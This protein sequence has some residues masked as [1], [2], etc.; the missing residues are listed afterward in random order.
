MYYYLYREPVEKQEIKQLLIRALV[1][2]NDDH[3]Q[4]L[5][6]E[7]LAKGYQNIVEETWKKPIKF[8]SGREA[9]DRFEKL[10]NKTYFQRLGVDDREPN[11]DVMEAI[12]TLEL[13][14]NVIDIVAVASAERD[15]AAEKGWWEF[16]KK[17]EERQGAQREN[18]K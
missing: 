6:A 4:M 12:E 16:C 1:G 18:V 5:F 8:I 2:L 9:L 10:Y 15:A 7:Y 11:S 17:E 14:K 3:E 13:T